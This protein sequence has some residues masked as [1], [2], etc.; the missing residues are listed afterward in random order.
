MHPWWSKSCRPGTK[1]L[2]RWP[3]L[4]S[5]HTVA[6][7]WVENEKPQP[8]ETFPIQKLTDDAWVWLRSD[9]QTEGRGQGKNTFFCPPGGLYA[10]L[11]CL[12]PNLAFTP[13]LSLITGLAIAETISEHSQLKWVNDIFLDQK[14]LGG[15]LINRYWSTPK[16]TSIISFGLNVN[17][18]YTHT[19]ENR[20]IAKWAEDGASLDLSDLFFRIET[21]LWKR[22]TAIIQNDGM[23]CP[24]TCQAINSRLRE[25]G[26]SVVCT[27]PSGSVE[28]IFQGITPSGRLNIGCGNTSHEYDVLTLCI[29]RQDRV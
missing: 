17:A 15:I 20:P 19:P 16:N 1:H 8:L 22:Y 6:Q 3:F 13:P 2:F 26:K 7:Q 23:L 21:Q 27:T 11:V 24:V 12:W 10:S 9:Q 29:S 28:G 4:S 14:K 5:T 25:F 18:P